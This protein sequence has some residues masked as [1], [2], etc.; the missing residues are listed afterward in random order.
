MSWRR[1]LRELLVLVLRTWPFDRGVDFMLRNVV[2]PL[3]PETDS[4]FYPVGDD[5]T[6]KLPAREKPGLVVRVEGNFE[7]AELDWVRRVLDPGDTALDVGANV[8]VFTVSMATSVGRSGRVIA[9]EPEPQNLEWLRANVL[10]NDLDHQVRVVAAAATERDGEEVLMSIGQDRSFTRV[11]DRPDDAFTA[12]GRS[13]DSIWRSADRPDVTLAKFDVEGH[14]LPALR[15]AADLL[16]SCGPRLLVE[17]NSSQDRE[18]IANFL[19]RFGYRQV[20]VAGLADRSC[21]FEA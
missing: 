7:P 21:V 15:G 19:G 1:G 16:K 4:V 14:E 6:V 18:S 20:E 8:G 2:R 10:R 5:V 3:V 12:S 9:L 13:L 17:A 11:T